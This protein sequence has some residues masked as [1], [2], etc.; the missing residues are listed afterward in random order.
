MSQ[1]SIDKPSKF[2]QEII[3]EY[4]NEGLVG[5][6]R[7][8]AQIYLSCTSRYLPKS[9]RLHCIVVSQS[10]SGK[11]TLLKEVTKPL[12]EKDIHTVSRM[13]NSAL[14]RINILLGENEY[15]HKILLYE[16]IDQEQSEEADQ[17][18]TLI[19][20]GRLNFWSAETR[21][22]KTGE[23]TLKEIKIN[24]MPIFLCT[25]TTPKLNTELLNRCLKLTMDESV[26][27]S[28]RIINSLMESY[29]SLNQIVGEE[30]YKISLIKYPVI[31]RLEKIYRDNRI[32]GVVIPF[33]N[34]VGNSFLS[35]NVLPTTIRRDFNKLINLTRIIAYS[36]FEQRPI[37]YKNPYEEG[38]GINPFLLAMPEDFLDAIY[39]IGGDLVSSIQGFIGKAKDVFKIMVELYNKEYE[40][41]G[42][43]AQQI[44][45]QIRL[46]QKMTYQYC[47][48]LIDQ[49]L[50]TKNRKGTTNFY[51]PNPDALDEFKF[52]IDFYREDLLEWAKSE[53]DKHSNNKGT[54]FSNIESSDALKLLPSRLDVTES[55][56]SMISQNFDSNSSDS[57]TESKHGSDA[58]AGS[59]LESS[60]C[61]LCKN[62]LGKVR[63]VKDK[64]N[65]IIL[66]NNCMEKDK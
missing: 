26:K 58:I 25:S 15:N 27:Q 66:C 13:T 21:D 63:F 16:Q 18:K 50:A 40:E 7:N 5:E 22:P 20:E 34:S 46:G 53:D 39:C 31:T 9:H 24:T 4:H 1:M 61:T 60:V 6:D 3:D 19:S 23:F 59:M 47:E 36:K 54:V 17:L 11:T 44:A 42:V 30:E 57:S 10:S 51:T 33:I 55:N 32:S 14:N 62:K 45:K 8:I 56:P 49:G 65:N 37:I 29:G 28:K 43:S 52:K 41:D 38:G 35:H 48:S 12:S 64:T 2:L